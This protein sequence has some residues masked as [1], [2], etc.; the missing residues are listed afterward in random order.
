LAGSE[1]VIYRYKAGGAI[2]D[3]GCNSGSFMESMIGPE[4]QL[5]GIEMSAEAARKAQARSG[6]QVFVGDILEANFSPESFDVITCFDVLEHVYEPRHV[7]AKVRKWLKPQ[8]I[9]YLVVPN[10]DS[11]AV[12]I[13]QSYW[14]GLELPR[15]LTHF[16]HDSLKEMLR[17]E[18]LEEAYLSIL[19]YPAIEESLRY[20]MDELFRRAGVS[21]TPLSMAPEP[22]IPWRIARKA[23]RI[24][25]L[26][27]LRGAISL[28]GAGECIQA[29]YKKCEPSTS[30]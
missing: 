27:I 18:G 15:H 4:W 30:V 3:L 22:G 19:R 17:A 20:A 12:R 28:A 8:G 5:Y 7:I 26:P 11:A 29:V 2:L 24:S 6:G 9:F 23:L 14:Y 21:R 16:S 13:F 25:I 1:D 10:I